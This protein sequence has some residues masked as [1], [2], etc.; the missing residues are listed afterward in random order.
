VSPVGSA[1]VLSRRAA[2][3]LGG[4]ASRDSLPAS[5]A[6]VAPGAP[7]RTSPAAQEAFESFLPAPGD[8]LQPTAQRGPGSPFSNSPLAGSAQRRPGLDSATSRALARLERVCGEFEG[9]FL[10]RML[11]TMRKS[12]LE[13]DFM[14]GGLAED[15]FTDQMFMALGQK[16]GRRGSLGIARILYRQLAPLITGQHLGATDKLAGSGAKAKETTA[17]TSHQ[18]PHPEG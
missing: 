10:A 13:S 11:Q 12:G 14:H 16:L 2:S 4:C 18:G 9:L 8:H 1:D 6:G 5:A 15:I 3:A 7:T 17:S